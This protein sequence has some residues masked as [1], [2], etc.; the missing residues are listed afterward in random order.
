MSDAFFGIESLRF[1]DEDEIQMRELMTS[2][3]SSVVK[4]KLQEMNPAWKFRRV[5][6]PL[7]TP[8]PFLSDSYDEDD[9]FITQVEKANTKLQMQ[10]NELKGKFNVL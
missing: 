8:K 6:G 9:I 2:R 1:Y 5:E 10:L 4:S 3:F 7:L